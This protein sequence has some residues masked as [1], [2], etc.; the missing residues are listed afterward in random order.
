[1][2][3]ALGTDTA[4]SG[5]VP[6]GFNN[7]VGLK[8]TPGRVG[9]SGVVPA[10]RSLDCVSMFALTVADA[11]QVLALIEGADEDDDYSAYRPGRAHLPPTLRIGI[12][13]EPQLDPAL[14]TPWQ[15]ALEHARALGHTLV[16]VDFA[17]LHAVA[18]MLYNGPWLAERHAAIAEWLRSRARRARSDRAPGRR[19]RAALLARPTRSAA[20]TDCA[21]C[22]SRSHRCGARSTC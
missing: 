10:C 14:R 18:D 11:A 9:T 22:S 16:P 21:P 19:R 4:G 2:P 17:P 7:I 8:P 3:F 13:A 15:Q 1:M 5:R 12:P 20:S 6:A